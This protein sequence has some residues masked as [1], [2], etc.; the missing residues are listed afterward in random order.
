MHHD[1]LFCDLK[2]DNGRMSSV[3]RWSVFPG[4]N[5]KDFSLRCYCSAGCGRRFTGLQF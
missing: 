2:V 5:L 3:C 1:S 4:N